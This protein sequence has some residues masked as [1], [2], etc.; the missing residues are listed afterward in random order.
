VY[1]QEAAEYSTKKDTRMWLEMEMLMERA[2]RN[3]QASRI[4]CYALYRID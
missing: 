2:C 4:D 1:D 3:Q